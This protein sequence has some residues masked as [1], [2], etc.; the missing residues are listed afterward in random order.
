MTSMHLPNNQD[1][2]F[3]YS[4]KGTDSQSVTVREVAIKIKGLHLYTG[5]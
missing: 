2:L 5:K 4:P 3:E 1:F